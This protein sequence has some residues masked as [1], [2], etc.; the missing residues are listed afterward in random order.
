MYR[1]VL[2]FI[3]YIIWLLPFE[4]YLY[5]YNGPIIINYI[6]KFLLFKQTFNLGITDIIYRVIKPFKSNNTLIKSNEHTYSLKIKYYI[7]YFILC[8]IIQYILFFHNNIFINIYFK[9]YLHGHLYFL[10]NYGFNADNII[11]YKYNF[12]ILGLL[13]YLLSCQSFYSV[14][15]FLYYLVN[16]L[17]D[18]YYIKIPLKYN[19]KTDNYINWPIKLLWNFSIIL[20][21]GTL[22]KTNNTIIVKIYKLN[23]LINA[24]PLII[25]KIFLW[26]EYWNL[27]NL[28]NLSPLS[29]IIRCH[30]NE[31]L[32]ILNETK[33]IINKKSI[34]L[35]VN[36]YNVPVLSILA[37]Y[38]IHD[39]FNISKDIKYIYILIN[40]WSDNIINSLQGAN[41]NKFE[42]YNFNKYKEKTVYIDNYFK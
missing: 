36:I 15:I 3:K 10:T 1:I 9:G 40:E 37:N 17:L 34:K 29:P 23:N 27:Y 11:I 8:I 21:N 16:Y 32:Y 42:I 24:C 30:Y 13:D 18:M 25:K 31:L 20:S 41:S 38:F 22:N 14:N 5:M 12:I 2:Y 19:I 39:K 28:F 33:S 4:I 7:C 26:P 35:V 6:Y